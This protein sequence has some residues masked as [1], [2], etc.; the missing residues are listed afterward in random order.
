MTVSS[1]SATA[2]IGLI[3]WPGAVQSESSLVQVIS[4]GVGLFSST[5]SHDGR[6]LAT[7]N[8][9]CLRV[10]NVSNGAVEMEFSDPNV[11]FS[12]VRILWSRDD[13][14]LVVCSLALFEDDH[15]RFDLLVF[16]TIE[17]SELNLEAYQQISYLKTEINVQED[18]EYEL[19]YELECFLMENDTHLV[20]CA[21][22]DNAQVTGVFSVPNSAS[23]AP[24]TLLDKPSFSLLDELTKFA[25]SP[26][27]R[28]LFRASSFRKCDLITCRE[29][30]LH[31]E[32]FDIA[33]K[34]SHVQAARWSPDSKFIA[35]C[36]EYETELIILRVTFDGKLELQS[37]LPAFTLPNSKSSAGRLHDVAFIAVDADSSGSPLLVALTQD[38]YFSESQSAYLFLVDVLTAQPLRMILQRP[39]GPGTLRVN[40]TH[41]AL[42]L[43]GDSG[44]I[45]EYSAITNE[46]L[47]MHPGRFF[48]KFPPEYVKSPDGRSCDR[49]YS[50]DRNNGCVSFWEASPTTATLPVDLRNCINATTIVDPP[51]RAV[52]DVKSRLGR[53]HANI[54]S[55]GLSANGQFLLTH[56]IISKQR[57]ILQH[58]YDLRQSNWQQYTPVEFGSKPAYQLIDKTAADGS[59]L[60]VLRRLELEL[61]QFYASLAVIDRDFHFF[62]EDELSKFLV[63]PTFEEATPAQ[64]QSIVGN[65]HS[66]DK[67][68][69]ASLASTD[70]L[71]KY[72]SGQLQHRIG[73]VVS[74]SK[75]STIV[76]SLVTM[77]KQ[78]GLIIMSNRRPRLVDGWNADQSQRFLFA[79]CKQ[80]C[81]SYNCFYMMH[82]VHIFDLA[83]QRRLQSFRMLLR[84]EWIHF[85]AARSR[86]WIMCNGDRTTHV[87]CYQISWP[88]AAASPSSVSPDTDV[89]R[90]IGS[91]V[92]EGVFTP[93]LIVGECIL[94]AHDGRS[95]L[96]CLNPFTRRVDW[97]VK[98]TKVVDSMSLAFDHEGGRLFFAAAT[99]RSVIVLHLSPS[100][101]HWMKPAASNSIAAAAVPFAAT[102]VSWKSAHRVYSFDPPNLGVD[103]PTFINLHAYD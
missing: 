29:S 55:V 36:S 22:S 21:N 69:L 72:M 24:A 87:I 84:T 96:I 31:I 73:L 75:P 33:V 34:G 50:A 62:N 64:I 14:R 74:N 102:S 59:T 83:S 101:L 1:S 76:A 38:D 67:V 61:E 95:S 16:S 23:N 52:I 92:V 80:N 45:Q 99:R 77:M 40:G 78:Q 30:A 28:Y 89:A 15:C 42:I 39:K 63:L 103:S 43:C 13:T 93:S 3:H 65:S 97:E 79:A 26:C 56:N 49:L 4:T 66:S 5:M 58:C 68:I 7:L 32:S 9:E 44:S 70:S 98:F 51:S 2:S 25:V 37:T 18:G 53:S 41:I 6:R 94:G 90:C 86:L 82:S 35:V 12:D 11:I 19:E 57:L 20:Y 10:W 27:Q 71:D 88:A 85:E 47:R 54:Y 81:G 48:W 8:G 60:V 46:E 91:I 17:Q 100:M